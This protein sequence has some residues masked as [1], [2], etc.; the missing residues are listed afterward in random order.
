M[1]LQLPSGAELE[2]Q[3][4]PFADAKALYQAVL[5][6]LKS[7]QV[8]DETEIDL[9]LVKDLFC[10]GFSSKKVEAALEKCFKKCLYNKLPITA[11]T[12]EPAEARGDYL[13]V[14]VEVAKENIAPFVKSLSAEFSQI[15]EI[16]RSD[17]ALRQQT[18]QS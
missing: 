6:E 1:I 13:K 4:A 3:L 17:L 5:E 11:D 9:G 8:R 16:L 18:T 7:I 14:C 10:V 15:R 2:I 12:W